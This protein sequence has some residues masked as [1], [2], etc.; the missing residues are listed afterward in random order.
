MP[1]FLVSAIA[2]DNGVEVILYSGVV[3]GVNKDSIKENANYLKY[4]GWSTPSTIDDGLQP[5]DVDI[6]ITPLEDSIKR[7]EKYI[8]EGKELFKKYYQNEE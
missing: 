5:E 6:E 1:Q 4:L 7:T 3:D 8:Q 2:Y